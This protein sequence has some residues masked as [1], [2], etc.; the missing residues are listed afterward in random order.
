[1][2]NVC[3]VVLRTFHDQRSV[4]ADEPATSS[5][6]HYAGIATTVGRLHVADQQITVRGIDVERP[7]QGGILYNITPS[8]VTL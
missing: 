5:L 8:N 3:R 6:K 2:D 7:A 1:M 4:I